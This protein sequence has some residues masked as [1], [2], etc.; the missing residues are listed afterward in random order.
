[1]FYLLLQMFVY[2]VLAMGI[3]AA[4]GWLYRNLQA[5]RQE[6]EAARAV[7]DARSKVPRLE[8]LLRGR[9]EQVDKLKGQYKQ[10]AAALKD[11]QEE[12]REIGTKLK[13]SERD[14]V[15]W[16]KKAEAL[17]DRQALPGEGIIEGDEEL[18]KLK[19]EVKVLR[20]ALATAVEQNGAADE[21]QLR[22]VE[23]RWR[24]A[25][26]QLQA[27]LA[28]VAASERKISELERERELHH[29]SLKVLSRQLKPTPKAV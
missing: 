11:C 23:N 27:A 8:S 4:A 5:Q 6:E 28:D 3:G 1:M 19:N 10:K 12:L 16:Q 21:A 2:L 18:A 14:A 7:N 17:E 20:S 24:S 22:K 9:D 13:S 29:K 26:S 25:E 15:R